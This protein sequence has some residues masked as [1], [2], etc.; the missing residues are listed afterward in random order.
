MAIEV[1]RLVEAQPRGTTTST[2]MDG[3]G[4]NG[5]WQVLPLNYKVLDSNGF[6]TVRRPD[7]SF[8]SNVI[9]SYATGGGNEQIQESFVS[10]QFG[11]GA[12]TYIAIATLPNNLAASGGSLVV[13]R[14]V[15][16]NNFTVYA[17]SAQT[18]VD[19]G[20]AGKSVTQVLMPFALTSSQTRF[21]QLQARFSRATL[22][23]ERAAVEV[24]AFNDNFTTDSYKDTYRFYGGL[25]IYKLK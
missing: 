3:G 14:L 17:K 19:A 5:N 9:A 22:Y 21:L 20:N 4:N 24:A 13:Y 15:D 6:V 10:G 16:A 2:R 12:G 7:L 23:W 18:Y 8:S 11:L 25:E 1:A